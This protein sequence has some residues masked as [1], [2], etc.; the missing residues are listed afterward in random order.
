MTVRLLKSVERRLGVS[1]KLLIAPVF[2]LLL[3]ALVTFYSVREFQ[4][5]D[6]RMGTVATDLA[7]ETAVATNVLINL[8][9]LRLWVFD[10]YATGNDDILSRFEELEAEFFSELETARNNI[11]AAERVA[12]IEQVEQATSKFVS[13]FKEDLV[14]AKQEVRRVVVEELDEYGPAASEALRR[15]IDGITNREPDS[16]LRVSLEQLIHEKRN[17]KP[18][19]LCA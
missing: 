3:F 14:P 10:Y 16:P 11:Q 8:Y 13:V 7:P 18:I 17:R 2:I 12:L 1:G 4:S 15:A 19:T 9:Q 5:L 6:E